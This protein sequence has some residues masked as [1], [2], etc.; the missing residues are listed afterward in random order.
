[1]REYPK[2]TQERGESIAIC[3][4]KHL[5]QKQESRKVVYNQKHPKEPQK[6]WV[7]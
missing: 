7:G 3:N 5:K 2:Q 1:M 6:G 4:Q